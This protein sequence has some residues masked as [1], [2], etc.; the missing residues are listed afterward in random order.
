MN[1]IADIEAERAR[2]I[3]Q[4][5]WS[6]EHDDY[7]TQGEIARAAAAYALGASYLLYDRQRRDFLGEWWCGEHSPVRKLW[8]WEW[9]WFKPTDNRR[10]LVKAGALIVAEIERIDRAAMSAADGAKP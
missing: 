5:G 7:H 8:P 2:Q 10:D 3:K 1:A 6:A 4:E 9:Q